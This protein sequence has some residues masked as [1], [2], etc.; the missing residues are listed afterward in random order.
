MTSGPSPVAKLSGA[1]AVVV[2]FAVDLDRPLHARAG[3]EHSFG[4]LE[5][6]E[7]GPLHVDLEPIDPR[8]P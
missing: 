7:L 3:G 5:H 8:D 1:G 2:A 6:V 4:A